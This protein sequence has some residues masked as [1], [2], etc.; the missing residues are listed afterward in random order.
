[1]KSSDISFI[2]L[3]DSFSIKG[4]VVYIG[5]G[6]DVGDWVISS[7]SDGGVEEWIFSHRC[8]NV[9]ANR[10]F[11]CRHMFGKVI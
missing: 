8:A 11:F 5:S 4:L 7:G 6:E 2:V 10:T 1:M 3:W 9:S